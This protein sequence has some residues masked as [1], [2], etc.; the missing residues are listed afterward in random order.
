MLPAV[1]T[2]REKLGKKEYVNRLKHL[3][4]RLR[5]KLKELNARLERVLDRVNAKQIL[6]KKKN[7]REVS[8]EHQIEIADKELENAQTQLMQYRAEI[9]RLNTK[10]QSLQE[11]NKVVELEDLVK[12]NEK[13][14][15]ELLKEIKQ[16]EKINHDQGNELTKLE[17]GQEHTQ[18][19]TQL[20]EKL[21]MWKDK[22]HKLQS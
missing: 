5:N 20:T 6:A 18:I 22:E 1:N 15:K 13:R 2:K 7:T 14:K 16:L 12:R 11:V 4:E 17:T 3:N 8:V 9:E 10:I 21:R 19:L